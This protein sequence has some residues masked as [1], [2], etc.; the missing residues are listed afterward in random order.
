MAIE[1]IV[2][3][4]ESTNTGVCSVGIKGCHQRLLFISLIESN[5]RTVD[6]LGLRV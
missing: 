6:L 4:A 2:F 3:E 5:D 1:K